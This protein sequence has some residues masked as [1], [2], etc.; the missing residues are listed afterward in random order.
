MILH[1]AG[2]SFGRRCQQAA[3]VTNVLLPTKFTAQKYEL[4]AFRKRNFS[5][6]TTR[7]SGPVFVKRTPRGTAAEKLKSRAAAVGSS[8]RSKNPMLKHLMMGCIPSDNVPPPFQLSQYG[9]ES[10]YTVRNPRISPSFIAWIQVS[11]SHFTA[12]F[13]SPRGIGME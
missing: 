11:P 1:L 13:A 2:N 6:D 10:L 4:V 9:E 3:A 7:R 5:K 8:Q 12:C